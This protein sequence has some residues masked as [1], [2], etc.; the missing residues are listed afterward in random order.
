MKDKSFSFQPTFNYFLTDRLAVGLG[1]SYS[2]S[3]NIRNFESSY[4]EQ[5]SHGLGIIPE[6][7]YYR[8][9]ADKLYLFGNSQLDFSRRVSFYRNDISNLFERWVPF[10]SISMNFGGGL[11]YFVTTKIQVEGYTRVLSFTH[12]DNLEFTGIGAQ[13]SFQYVGLAF[14][15]IF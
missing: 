7:R 10:S 3:Q 9:L 1:L 4:N 15:F 6:I 14:R 8:R 13:F 11:A 12:R 2:Y 5:Y